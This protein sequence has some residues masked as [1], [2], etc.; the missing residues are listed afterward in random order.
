MRARA[1]TALATGITLS[2]APA[3]GADPPLNANNCAGF[4]ASSVVAGSQGVPSQ[5]AQA[6]PGAVAA[7]VLPDASCGDNRP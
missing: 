4:F 3:A 7:A 6:G 5:V 2:L 1:I